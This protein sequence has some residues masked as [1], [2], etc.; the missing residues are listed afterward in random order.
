MVHFFGLNERQCLK[1]FIHSAKTA[2]E[3]DKGFGIFD[4]HGFAYKEVAEIKRDV[5]VWIRLLFKGEFYVATYRDVSTFLCPFVGS[6]HYAR[7]SAGYNSK[8]GFRDYSCCLHRCDSG[9]IFR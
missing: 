7:A 1:E 4:E 8:P 6:F 2:R 3:N 5:K 9:S